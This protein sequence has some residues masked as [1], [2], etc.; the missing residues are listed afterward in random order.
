MAVCALVLLSLPLIASEKG[1]LIL[2]L[3]F[4]KAVEERGTVFKLKKI[5]RKG[6]KTERYKGSYKAYN[7]IDETLIS[8]EFAYYRPKGLK[9]KKIPL[10]IIVPPVLGITP[11]DY[12]AASYLSSKGLGVAV[13]KLN[14]PTTDLKVEVESI[15]REWEG[16]VE[17]VRAFIDVAGKLPSVDK[18]KI[19]IMGLSLGG[20]TATLSMGRD[21]RLK[22]A[23]I[24]MGSGNLPHILAYSVQAVVRKLRKEKMKKFKIGEAWD[25]ETFLKEKIKIETPYLTKGRDSGDYYLFITKKDSYI[26]GRS[27]MKLR[28]KLGFPKTTFLKN[29]HVLNGILYPFHLKKIKDYFLSKFY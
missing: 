3:D 26:P 28:D 6:L 17:K 16:Y 24:F 15:G 14:V 21:P 2:D 19:G 29:G 1:P 7:S 18:R 11:F 12:M 22:A 8:H 5:F 13:L 25:F 23:V 27:Q 20:I 10:I 9:N 4:K